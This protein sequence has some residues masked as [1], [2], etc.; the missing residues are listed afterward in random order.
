M[1][2]QCTA[3]DRRRRLRPSPSADFRHGLVGDQTGGGRGQT[4]FIQVR[5]TNKPPEIGRRDSAGRLIDEITCELA[6]PD[7]QDQVDRTSCTVLRGYTG[8]TANRL[9]LR[10]SVKDPDSEPPRVE[11]SGRGV[12]TPN[13][14]SE[15]NAY[16]TWDSTGL[17]AGQYTLTATVTENRGAGKPASDFRATRTVTVTVEDYDAPPEIQDP[18]EPDRTTECDPNYRG[19]LFVD[20]LYCG[21]RHSTSQ[22]WTGFTP[23]SDYV[24]SRAVGST[25]QS[26]VVLEDSIERTGLRLRARENRICGIARGVCGEYVDTRVHSEGGNVYQWVNYTP[27]P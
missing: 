21:Q 24:W 18:E 8:G 9:R 27:E 11:W 14:P 17:S 4:A 2:V 5:D 13:P 15:L 12:L 16:A 1:P 6:N 20:D 3:L 23:H 19:T 26:S 25:G 10:L 7:G 22:T